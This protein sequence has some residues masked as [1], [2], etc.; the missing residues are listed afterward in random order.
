MRIG[1]ALASLSPR[2]P[3]QTPLELPS[4][5]NP[6]RFGADGQVRL[7]NCYA[8]NAGKEGKIPLPLYACDGL[9]SFATLSGGGTC[10]GML[11]TPSK[12]FVVSG[13]LMFAVG[14]GGDVSVLGGIPG[15]GPV[16]MA[17][18]RASPFEVAVAADGLPFI[19]TNSD[20]L[21]AISDTDLQPPSN[22]D[23]LDGYI[24]YGV[25]NGRFYWSAID[26]ADSIDALAFAEA[27]GSPD[28]LKRL[29]VHNRTIWLL[30]DDSTELWESTGDVN[31]PFQRSPG[32]FFETG[33]IA[34]AS[35]VTLGSG[36]AWVSNDGHVIL[37]NIGGGFQRIS[38]HAVEHDI[39]ALSEGDKAAIEGFVYKRNGHE[40]YVLSSSA[41]T[42]IYDPGIGWHERKSYG[43]ERWRASFYAHFADKHIVGDIENGVLYEIDPD[44]Y[45]EAGTHLVMTA[46]VPI[47]AWPNCVN[48][49][50]L[51]IDAIPGVGLNSANLHNS[52]PQLMLSLS[53][54]GGKSFGNE[55][56]RSIGKI[57]Q[58]TA[59]TEFSKLGTSNEDGFVCAVSAS[60]AVIRA[61]TGIAAD[62]EIVRR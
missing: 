46:Q 57:G 36:V 41:F 42:W 49:K 33:C 28:G 14:R 58:Y 55:M 1:A 27:E 11:A 12:L 59:Q 31:S 17:R 34:P 38:T 13:R 18:N 8:E 53:K 61:F 40:F 44:T 25:N 20:T 54:N 3:R 60:A 2:R 24:L 51:R 5:S 48:L 21:T 23:F 26:D 62:T 37:A 9:A 7:I 22:L 35:V 6:G 29:Y 39:D 16:Y 52:D 10:R 32:A 47:N 45:T 50:R 15:S 56:T 43:E 19:I 4:Q 30:G